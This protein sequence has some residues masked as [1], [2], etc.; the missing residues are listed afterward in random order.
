[1]KIYT[2][3]MFMVV[4]SVINIVLNILI[5]IHVRSSSRRIQPQTVTNTLSNGGNNQQARVSRRDISLLQQMI[6]MFLISIAGWTPF[7]V[8]LII[9]SFIYLDPVVIRFAVLWAELCILS[10]IINLFQRN[11]E[12]REYSLNKIK[13]L[14]R[15]Q[16][17]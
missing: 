11:H 1:M 6:F 13:A 8:I 7:Y 12:I 5:F 3:V 17:G 14:F 15:L 16:T 2:F 9:T 4:P 10:I